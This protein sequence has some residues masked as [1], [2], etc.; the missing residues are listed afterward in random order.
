[1][2]RAQRRKHGKHAA[3]TKLVKGAATPVVSGSDD[4]MIGQHEGP[5]HGMNST[6]INLPGYGQVQ[7]HVGMKFRDLIS[8]GF[9]RQIA[10]QQPEYPW[11]RGSV[12]D[13][14]LEGSN[15]D[16]DIPTH[17][18]I[19]V[20]I[21]NE[22]STRP[23]YLEDPNYLFQYITH[24][25]NNSDPKD[26]WYSRNMWEAKYMFN[27]LE[28]ANKIARLEGLHPFGTQAS[29]M[30][31]TAALQATSND[32][33]IV[34]R[35]L[36]LYPEFSA[37]DGILRIPPN[38][39]RTIYFSL[40][41]LPFFQGRFPWPAIRSSP[42]GGWKYRLRMFPRATDG[43]FAKVPFTWQTAAPLGLDGVI[44]VD[45]PLGAQTIPHHN[46]D[47]I[48]AENWQIWITG[49]NLPAGYR[50]EVMNDYKTTAFNS[51]SPLYQDKIVTDVKTGQQSDKIELSSFTGDIAL[52]NAYLM[53]TG[54]EDQAGGS[55]TDVSD[56]LLFNNGS[57]RDLGEF[58]SVTLWS[59]GGHPLDVQDSDAELLCSQRA[60]V[61]KTPILQEFGRNNG[62]EQVINP[63][64][65]LSAD[66]VINPSRA[67]RMASYAFCK[68][69]NAAHYTGENTGA[70]NL[71]GANWQIQ[72]R[73]GGDHM[74]IDGSGGSNG[75]FDGSG[76]ARLYLTA[77]RYQTHIYDGKEWQ[78]EYH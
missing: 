2:G 38:T 34:Q 28:S 71:T 1:M 49:D 10:Q 77:Y 51:L 40:D 27:D 60:H 32:S 63:R 52:I 12:F 25:P 13:Y 73:Y 41:F 43:I 45:G 31:T 33:G 76:D 36:A 9:S 7:A 18:M 57:I 14:E 61:Y 53:S 67:P 37:R 70:M 55:L 20:D 24:Q 39:T 46:R 72:V 23:V 4:P 11:Y 30:R 19:S 42:Q 29:L 69:A 8:Q 15:M 68:D 65:M 44:I 35:P 17:A 22:N 75:D 54:A 16:V 50:E 3:R 74:G 78:V 58:Q 26:W 62:Q 47:E 6:S 5:M 59:A 56:S 66:T 64:L 48:R 21:T